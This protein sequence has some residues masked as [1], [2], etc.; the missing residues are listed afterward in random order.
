MQSSSDTGSSTP[1]CAE[2]ATIDRQEI[3]PVDSRIIGFI[4]RHHV[5]TLATTIHD[6]PHC[7]SLFYAYLPQ[8]NLFAVTSSDKTWHVEQLRQNSRVAAAV[9]LE[10]KLVGK[11]Q[12]LQIRGRMYRP[13]G[14]ELAA[15]KKAYLLRFPYAAVM[16]P[17]MWVIA[18]DYLKLTDNRLGFG[19]KLLW[20]ASPVKSEQTK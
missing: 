9:V 13:V 2:T 3:T 20:E 1:K 18:P 16:D 8:R 17:E 4:K 15:A 7:S 14:E 12:G 19:T 5:L 10:T 6:E 11:I